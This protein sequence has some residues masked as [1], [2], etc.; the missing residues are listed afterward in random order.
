MGFA[1]SITL[2][3][4]AIAQEGQDRCF[5]IGECGMTSIVGD[6]LVHQPAEPLDR[7]E[8]GTIGGDEMQLDAATG[9]A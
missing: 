9:P 6:V 7:I 5:E 2:Q 3:P 8:V 4:R 1:G